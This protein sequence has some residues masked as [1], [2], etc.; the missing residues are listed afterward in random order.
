MFNKIQQKNT[1]NK[2]ETE[3]KG[4]AYTQAFK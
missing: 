2:A 3:L 1:T 4:F